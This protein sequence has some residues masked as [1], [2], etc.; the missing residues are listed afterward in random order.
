MVN[1]RRRVGFTIV[2]LVI[3]I[4]VIAVLAAILIPTFVSITKKANL[5]ADM[6]AVKE[7]NTILAAE[8]ITDG[9]PATVV[10]AKAVLSANG[11]KD[12]TPMSANSEFYWIGSENRVILWEWESDGKTT[13]KVTYPD[14]FVKKYKSITAP[15]NDWS[16]LYDNYMVEVITPAEGEELSVAL[17]SAVENAEDGAILQ[18][19]KG[20]TVD[21]GAGGLDALGTNMQNNGGTGK[22]LT[23]D[24]NGGKIAS[25]TPDEDGN[26]HGGMVPVGG[27][28][29]LINGS[30]DV[31][32][33]VNG[34]DVEAGAHL[35]LRDVE[36]NVPEGDAI[37]PA[38][39]A[40]EIILENCKIVAGANYAVATNNQQSDNIYIKVTNTTLQSGSCALLV[41]VP[42][43]V[44]VE[45]STIIGGGWGMFVRSGHATIK[46]STIKTTDGDTGAN[47]SR[48]NTSCEYFVYNSSDSN[49][50]YW[51]SGAQA[52]YAPLI[53][54][55]YSNHNAYNHDTECNL[56]NV[57]F[58]NANSNKIPDIV[59]A[60]R[61]EGKDVVLNYDNS[62]AVSRLV[63]YGEGYVRTQFTGLNGST[64]YAINHVFEHKGS[65]TIN[66]DIKLKYAISSDF[67]TFAAGSELN[68]S[69]LNINYTE[70]YD[71]ATNVK[72][73]LLD[74]YNIFDNYTEAEWGTLKLWFSSATNGDFKGYYDGNGNTVALTRE[75]L[76]TKGIISENC[77]VTLLNDVSFATL[78]KDTTVRNCL[79]ELKLYCEKIGLEITEEQWPNA[80][81]VIGETNT[82]VDI[83]VE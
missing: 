62:T 73:Y 47:D 3:V 15:S 23:I 22:N 54:G 37:F 61:P 26:Y 6:V 46:N 8:E 24:L 39:N 78:K 1:K 14:E 43:D 34:F 58:D 21:L 10:D 68:A 74:N 71:Y 16:N 48:Y 11:I 19:P 60:A 63:I 66:G 76:I 35:I 79:D 57:N 75:N 52:P 36:L 80:K 45:D 9:K 65:I 59:V 18:L 38:G 2:E 49:I 13:G 29:T 41:N 64:I 25:L 32:G 12:F 70:G 50:P 4:A 83:V 81:I 67:G 27:S 55:D 30:I 40:S 72:K 7:M 69:D 28:L 33:K 56:T 53:V 77:P 31:A 5:S 51:G 20:K 44:I 17:L 82:I 42:C